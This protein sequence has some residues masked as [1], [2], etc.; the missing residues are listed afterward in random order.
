[1]LA[2]SL[3][4]LTFFSALHYSKNGLPPYSVKKARDHFV[5]CSA[6]QG[7]G[8]LWTASLCIFWWG[9][10]KNVAFWDYHVIIL[11]I[12]ELLE[13]RYCSAHTICGLIWFLSQFS[14][15]CFAV[16]SVY[17]ASPVC[18]LSSQPFNL[19]WVMAGLSSVAVLLHCQACCHCCLFHM[20]LLAILYW[21]LAQKLSLRS[22]QLTHWIISP[23]SCQYSPGPCSL[24]VASLHSSSR[25]I[26]DTE[27]ASEIP[28]LPRQI[29]CLMKEQ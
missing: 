21:A 6:F 2:K 13:I 11:P 1:M 26:S 5:S 24:S 15:I 17:S 27:R 22:W 28:C 25:T 20:S 29:P 7:G 12:L 8:C 19:S 4:G 3:I 16:S 9:T 23:F 10:G 14:F 18:A